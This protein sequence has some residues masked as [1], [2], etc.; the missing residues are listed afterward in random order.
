MVTYI[1]SK[2][3]DQYRILFD[4]A[5]KALINNP[6]EGLGIDE[7]FTISTL[8]EYFAYL[9]NLV[10]VSNDE[11]ISRFF[12]RLPLDEDFFEIDANSRSIKVPST[13]FGRYG[14]GVQGDEL[15]EVVYFTIDRYFDST[16]LASDEINIVIQW[17]AR[18]ENKNLVAGIS[19]HFGKDIE[20]IPGKIIF[21]WPIS[22]ELTKSS[23]TVKFAVRFYQ[24]G[25]GDEQGVHQL[26]YNFSTLP[27][28]VTV[29]AS[30]NYDLVNHAVTEID[31]GKTI[32]S[33]IKNVGIYD[34]SIPIPEKPIVTIPLYVLSPEGNNLVKIVDLPDDGT[35]QVKLAVSAK[36]GDIGVIGYD[37]K[38]FAYNPISGSYEADSVG[39]SS[40]ETEFIEVPYTTILDEDKE[41]YTITYDGNVINA[42][43][44]SKNR[45]SNIETD[46]EAET[47]T[48]NGAPISL[49]QKLSVAT[50][51]TVGEYAVDVTARAKVN[52]SIRSMGKDERIRIP[53]P[54]KPV[55]SL[56]EE[57][58]NITV[59]EEDNTVHA[60]AQNGGVILKVSA[61]P[62]ETGK[63]ETEVGEAPNVALTF[64]WKKLV[65][66]VEQPLTGGTA[67]PMAVHILPVEDVPNDENIENA[68]FNQGAVTLSQ[69]GNNV[70]IYA[71]GEELKTYESTN[72]SQGAHK[73][74][75][76]DIDTGFD[77]IVGAKWNGYVLT[78]DDVDEAETVN[79]GAGHIIF[80]AKADALPVDVV[81]TEPS[82][83]DEIPGAEITL[84]FGFS[85]V[86]PSNATYTF[87]E[88]EN[89]S[90]MTIVG[91]ASEALDNSYIAEVISTR[92]NVQTSENSGVYRVTNAP[93]KPVLSY[94]GAPVDTTIHAIDKRDIRGNYRTLTF[95]I[96]EPALSDGITYLWM[97]AVV[98]NEADYD[99]Y[100]EIKAQ[101]DLD[102]ALETILGNTRYPGTR[103][104][105][106]DNNVAHYNNQGIIEFGE[107][108][109]QRAYQL[110]AEDDG[111]YYCIVINELNNNKAASIGP[112][113]RVS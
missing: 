39:I 18:D 77:T 22:S 99:D 104:T 109:G 34:P 52:T 92:N 78:Q 108:S 98:D 62:G 94:G 32:T 72:P 100:G 70:V 40:V 23:G 15:A 113:F 21:G 93:E 53:G 8:N 110:T 91:L 57:E 68:K 55:V 106:L 2:N 14:I 66:G 42:T 11:D 63:P 86:M 82:E 30:L 16:D 10:K 45:I 44:V 1:S 90:E 37:W 19:Q 46:S 101:V 69:A 74:I 38:K 36:P 87:N 79:L 33:R 54:L 81:I 60:I 3:A 61:T 97:R 31:H 20:T 58:D 5:A 6:P 49:Y 24:L 76:L 107:S 47:F 111:I 50:V 17:E 67:G 28:E 103:D 95:N 48:E 75:A 64:K 89:N 80:W 96:T 85:T 88:D 59:T 112:F 56:P 43:L 27:A 41:Y 73:W 4:K 26:T 25:E 35:S 65:G 84:R 13:S 105:I 9:E 12:V 102:G 51:T 7:S 29:N 71:T 83:D